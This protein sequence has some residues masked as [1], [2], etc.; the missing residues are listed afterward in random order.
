MSFARTP[1]V[2][3]FVLVH[4]SFVS[5]SESGTV[6][7]DDVFG[8]YTLANELQC[9]RLCWYHISCASYSY[10]ASRP[11]GSSPNC[12]LHT[13]S[14]VCLSVSLSISVLH[15]GSSVCL[16]LFLSLF[17]IQIRLFCTQVLL[18]V[19][20]PVSLSMS[21]LHTGSSVCL[22]V[23]LFISAAVLHTGSSV[24]LSAYFSFY[25][26]FAYRFV[27]LSVCLF[28]ILSLSLP[29]SLSL[30]SHLCVFRTFNINIFI[31]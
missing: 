4:L 12:V 24:C 23:S 6:D 29:P 30:L 10:L 20:L 21:V 5:E 9:Q 7:R 14:S 27:C 2:F 15:T 26:C 22:S 28:L 3:L 11:T 17:C 31:C 25:L 19:C 13:G 8:R 18:S 16:F 1:H